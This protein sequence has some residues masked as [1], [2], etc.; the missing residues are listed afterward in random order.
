MNTVETMDMTHP[1][2]DKEVI[3]I[4]G[5]EPAKRSWRAAR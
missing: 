3:D 2:W 4:F 5:F 1:W